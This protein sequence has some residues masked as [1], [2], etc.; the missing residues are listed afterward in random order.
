MERIGENRL[1]LIILSQFVAFDNPEFAAGIKDLVLWFGI[2][3]K[4]TMKSKL[5]EILPK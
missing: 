3:L 5:E 2:P 4:L 1:S